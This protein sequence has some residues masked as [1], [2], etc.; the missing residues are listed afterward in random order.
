MRNLIRFLI[1]YNAVFL[2]I[3]LEIISFSLVVNNDRKGSAFWSSANGV[4]GVF[5]EQYDKFIEYLNFR[6]RTDRI[7]IIN[8]EALSNTLFSK[9]YEGICA[10]RI[11]DTAHHQQFNYIAAKVINN[12]VGKFSNYL[13]INRGWLHGVRPNM[14]VINSTGDGIA[15]IVL[16][17]SRHYAVVMSVLHKDSKI[18]ARVK[19][20][21]YF[22]SLTWNGENPRYMQLEAIPKHAI[23]KMG[24]T[25]VTSGYSSIFPTEM[26]IGFVENFKLESGSNFYTINVRL[27]CEMGALEHAHVVKNLMIDEQEILEK[28]TQEDKKKK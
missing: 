21:R 28:R 16:N 11:I 5:N 24:D 17:V 7:H 12:S 13:T 6:K 15:G 19:S 25:I 3:L 1:Y 9:Y 4:V 22:G 23:M 14:G 8:S 10:D 20:N 2:F 18:S 26:L 27:N